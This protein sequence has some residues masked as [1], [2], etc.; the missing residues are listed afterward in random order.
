MYGCTPQAAAQKSRQQTQDDVPS[1]RNKPILAATERRKR[2]KP[3]P[4]TKLISFEDDERFESLRAQLSLGTKN[5]QCGGI[6]GGDK[7]QLTLIRKQRP[8]I[9]DNHGDNSRKCRSSRGGGAGGGSDAAA[10]R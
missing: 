4:L 3:F 8:E 5:P 2:G 10:P 6:G 1:P 9:T 7:D